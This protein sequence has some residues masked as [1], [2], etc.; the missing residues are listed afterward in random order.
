MDKK[1]KKRYQ[2][3]KLR[4][5][6]RIYGTAERPRLSVFRSLKHIY[7][8]LI[9]DDEGKTYVAFSS[10]SPEFKKLGLSGGN[11]QGARKIGELFA[12]KAL[13]AGFKKVVFCR[14]ALPYH[15]RIK[16]LAEGARSKG[17]EF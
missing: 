2:R 6:R 13:A 17:L 1:Q 15:G 11:C 3:R 7:A 5:R 16:A 4:V 10:L 14:G 12:E 8:Q 9:R